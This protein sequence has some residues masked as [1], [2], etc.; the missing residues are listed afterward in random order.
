M[1]RNYISVGAVSVLGRKLPFKN[2][3][4]DFKIDVP[5][6]YSI[7]TDR[8]QASGI[9][10]GVAMNGGRYLSAGLHRLMLDSPA[11][12]V[13]IIWSRAADKGFSPFRSEKL[14]N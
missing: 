11:N 2:D 7:I 13:A 9:L 1:S 6:Q 5:Q 10:D 3:H 4:L 14:N 8:G 12:S